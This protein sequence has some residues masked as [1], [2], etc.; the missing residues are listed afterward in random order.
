MSAPYEYVGYSGTGSFA[1]AGGTN[2]IGS[3]LYLGNNAGSFGTYSLGGSSSLTASSEYIGYAGAGS[4]AQSGGTNNAGT[5]MIG[6]NSGG[7]GV[8]SL[9][10]SGRVTANFEYVGRSGTG[11]F[12]QSG[13]TNT[14]NTLYVGNY[15]N[16]RYDLNGGLLALASMYENSVAGSSFNFTGGTLRASAALRR[17][18]PWS[19]ARLARQRSIRP[20]MRRLLPV[21]SPAPAL[22]KT[23]SGRLLLAATNSYSGKTLISGGTLA[24]GNALALQESTLDTS[25][26]GTFNFGSLSTA[27][28][29]GLTGSGR[30]YLEQYCHD[31]RGPQRGQ[32]RS[33]RDVFRRAPRRRQ[34]D[35]DRQR[36]AAIDRQQ[37]LFRPDDDQ[38]R[39]THRQRLA[40]QPGD[41]QQR[42]HAGRHGQPVER[43]G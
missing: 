13:G 17:P 11:S 15:G 12:A 30:T 27:T 23:G 36:H 38:P 41:G 10:G 21:R 37:Y 31:R 8:Y 5:V 39:R 29:G 22:V 7:S 35:Q 18:A 14:V 25:G 32:Q 34:S 2:S 28:L 4:F 26:S 43:H 9:S 6:A 3:Y 40:P 24:L 20:A 19:W 42:R 33:Q 16:G 1:Q